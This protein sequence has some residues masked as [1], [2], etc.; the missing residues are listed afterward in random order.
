MKIARHKRDWEDLAKIDPLWAV[1]SD[2]ARQY[3]GWN[4]QE[5][6]QT[7][8]VEIDAVMRRVNELRPDLPRGR[9]LDFGCGVGRLTRALTSYFGRVTGVDISESMIAQAR[10]NC[11]TWP[12]EFFLNVDDNLSQIEDEQFDFVYTCKV[13]QHQ[14][15][16]RD[17][18]NY[19]SAFVRILKPAG[20]AVFQVPSRLPL[21]YRL[22][23]RRWTYALLR[24]LRVS[25]RYLYRRLRLNPIKMTTV[26]PMAI[27]RA[28]QEAG[29]R[30]LARDASDDA[31][32]RVESFMY[33]VVK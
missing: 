11:A 5:F 31:G 24:T 20:M 16:T 13:L 14:P 9:A 6:Y 2:P 17:V 25:E 18:L 29:G 22:N 3:G 32:P 7:G 30:I 26:S 28:V 15:S 27:A 19:V 10:L 12:C 4:E 23:W 1:L 33:Y 8:L 21:R